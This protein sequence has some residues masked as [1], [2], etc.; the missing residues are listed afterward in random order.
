MNP[1]N[2]PAITLEVKQL[3]EW[4]L[5]GP[6]EYVTG[7]G[8]AGK[9]FDVGPLE[10]GYRYCPYCGKTLTIPPGHQTHP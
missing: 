1:P 7:C 5:N 2:T 6:F 8:Q 9:Y 3:C 4:L 10:F